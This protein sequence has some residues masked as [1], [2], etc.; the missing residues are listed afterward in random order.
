MTSRSVLEGVLIQG[1]EAVILFFAELFSQ[2]LDFRHRTDG[3]ITFAKLTFH[4]PLALYGIVASLL[5][6]NFSRLIDCS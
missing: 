3:T 6:V 1:G 2:T 4:G 5:R